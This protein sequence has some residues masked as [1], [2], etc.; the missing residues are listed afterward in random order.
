[1]LT[2][3]EIANMRATSAAALPDTVLVTRQGGDPVLDETTGDLD[4]PA[5]TTV[6]TGAARVRPRGTSEQSAEV[7]EL[8]ETLGDYVATL[9]HTVTDVQVDDFLSVTA[10]S[11]GGMVG[12]SFRVV[13]VGWSSWQIDRR[14]GL[15]DR[16]QPTGEVG[17]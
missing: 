16:E 10:S 8:H 4:F 11:D 3:A 5:P 6:Y 14:V 7:G 17:S 1:M 12:R 13:H 2:E 9:P 15:E